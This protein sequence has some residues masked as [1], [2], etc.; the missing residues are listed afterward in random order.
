MRFSYGKKVKA[1]PTAYASLTAYA[2]QPLFSKNRLSSI[3]HQKVLTSVQMAYYQSQKSLYPSGTAAGDYID[4]LITNLKQSSRNGSI[5]PLEIL[6]RVLKML[7]ATNVLA[8]KKTNDEYAS[9]PKS[10]TRTEAN[11]GPFALNPEFVETTRLA[12]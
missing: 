10:N 5:R 11:I 2:A 8:P 4:R 6:S 7:F 12:T 3:T 9:L 1:F